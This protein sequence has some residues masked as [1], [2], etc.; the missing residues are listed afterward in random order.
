MAGHRDAKECIRRRC[1]D[2]DIATL[3]EKLKSLLEMARGLKPGVTFNMLDAAAR[4]WW[5]SRRSA[6][7]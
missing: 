1:H 5:P 7:R 2:Q 6:W 3:Y 4:A